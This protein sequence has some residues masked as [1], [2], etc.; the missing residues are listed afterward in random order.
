M[1]YRPIIL[2]LALVIPAISCLAQ[3]VSRA[4]RRS[5]VRMQTHLSVLSHDSLEGR[6]AGTLGEQKASTYIQEVFKV[7]GLQPKGTDGSF[8]QSFSI[9]DGKRWQSGSYLRLNGISLDPEKDFI[10]FSVSGN[11]MVSSPGTLPAVAEKG[12]VWF[13]DMDRF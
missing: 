6:R 1:R 7:I 13:I 5:L 4:G 2:C 8:L 3:Q 9:P 10:P 11:G 12:Q